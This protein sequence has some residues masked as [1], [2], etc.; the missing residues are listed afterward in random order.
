[1]ERDPQRLVELERPAHDERERGRQVRQRDVAPPGTMYDEPPRA[2]QKKPE[3]GDASPLA[4]GDPGVARQGERED[5]GE[6]GGVEEMLAVEPE[7]ELAADGRR[8]R[9]DR[10]ERG[11]RSQEQAQRKRGD[12]S[13]PRVEMRQP[14][15]ERPGEL[16]EKSRRDDQ[17][18]ARRRDVESEKGRSVHEQSQQRQDLPKARIGAAQ[19]REGELGHRR[20]GTPAATGSSRVLLDSRYTLR[21]VIRALT[22]SEA[23]ACAAM[24]ASSE[25]W[26]TLGRSY[27]DCLSRMT[28]ESKERFVAA[29]ADGALMGF[30]IVNMQ[31]PFPG[32]IQTVCVAA[33]ER[34]KGLG[35]RLVAF[36]EQRI[37]RESPNVFLCVSSF[38]PGARRLY[39]R[40]GYEEIGVLRDYLV[41]GHAEI[42]MRKSIGSLAEFRGGNAVEEDEA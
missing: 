23:P 27:D 12:E 37:F 26:K 36:A 11:V 32:Y 38:N 5:E 29:E 1:M 19:R 15:R 18:R 10:D 39:E 34:G 9:E 2:D 41:R 21:M 24:M 25:P 7:K 22:P 33:E 14:G 30:I 20:E 16:D 28:D 13:A 42:L 31:G 4:G 3:E 6:V 8:R 40:L 35:A 17:G